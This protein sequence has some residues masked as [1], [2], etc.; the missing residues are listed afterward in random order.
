MTKGLVRIFASMVYN[1][2]RRRFGRSTKVVLIEEDDAATIEISYV[3][4]IV[5]DSVEITLKPATDKE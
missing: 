1:E 5:T 4:P 3:K 2:F